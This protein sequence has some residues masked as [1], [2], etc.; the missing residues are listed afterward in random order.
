MLGI[1]VCLK[2]LVYKDI[3]TGDEI[4]IER[5][6]RFLIFSVNARDYVFDPLSGKLVGTGMGCRISQPSYCKSD[7]KPQLVPFLAPYNQN[8]PR[9]SNE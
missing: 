1:C 3:V 9:G 2:P 4:R 5:P 7:R 8:E 6:E